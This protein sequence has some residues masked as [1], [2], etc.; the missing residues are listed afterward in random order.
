MMR[1]ACVRGS[2]SDESVIDDFV[3]I[4]NVHRAFFDDAALGTP[5]L[6]RPGRSSAGDLS[7]PARNGTG[8][9]LRGATPSPESAHAW[10]RAG[11]V[12]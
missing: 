12:S 2:P 4:A 1:G 8:Q 7:H 10:N 11:P 9:N 6:G 5:A 3:I